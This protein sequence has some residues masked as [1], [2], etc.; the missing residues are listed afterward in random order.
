MGEGLDFGKGL[1]SGSVRNLGSYVGIA[2]I[3][4]LFFGITVLNWIRSLGSSSRNP[5]C[6]GENQHYH[7]P[8]LVY[9][10]CYSAHPLPAASERMWKTEVGSWGRAVCSHGISV[11]WLGKDL[12]GH[13]IQAPWHVQ[14]HTAPSNL[15]LSTARNGAATAYSVSWGLWGVCGVCVSAPFCAREKP[16]FL[17][18]FPCSDLALA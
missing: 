10:S 11:V 15:A 16:Y 1:D 9:H 13:L 3:L 4:H 5:L 14:G 17:R 2:V 8:V 6:I 12:N 18:G 7:L